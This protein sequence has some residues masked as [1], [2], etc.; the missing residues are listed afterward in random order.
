MSRPISEGQNAAL[1]AEHGAERVIVLNVGPDQLAFLRHDRARCL[2]MLR[3]REEGKGDWLELAARQQV[4]SPDAPRA[5]K[6]P[7]EDLGLSDPERAAII[8]ERKRLEQLLTGAPALGS[9]IGL[10][11]ARVVGY[12]AEI[13]VKEEGGTYRALVWLTTPDADEDET[14]SETVL[15]E[16]RD[17]KPDFVLTMRRMTR[18]EYGAYRDKI[19]TLD[20]GALL[21]DE[22]NAP[23]IFAQV[24]TDP[25]AAKIANEYP[26]LAQRLALMA[27]GFGCENK[28]VSL[29]KFAASATPKPLLSPT[30]PS[31]T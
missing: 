23:G 20:Q 6:S 21:L 5:G 14:E 24:C 3:R 11:L 22:E 2:D 27:T 13:D 9:V 19:G 28:A 29:K 10:M 4:L 7:G 26:L 12:Q 15:L 25:Q 31:S 17:E 30:G 1:C 16:S 8:G 18:K